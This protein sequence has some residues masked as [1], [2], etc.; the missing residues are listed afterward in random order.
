MQ[1]KFLI[2]ST[3]Y[4]SQ[5]LANFTASPPASPPPLLSC[6][7]PIPSFC[8]SLAEPHFYDVSCY[9]DANVSVSATDSLISPPAYG[10]LGCN[11]GGLVCCRFCEFG[12]YAN[13]SC[14]ESPSP[15]P[16]PPASPPSLPLPPLPPAPPN[17]P[18][19]NAPPHSPRPCRDII[20][21]YCDGLV[22]AHYFDVN[23]YAHDDA[24]G[25]L[26]CNAG[27]R[28]CCRFCEFGNY[29]N[30]SCIQSP[31]PPPP[32]NPLVLSIPISDPSLDL[33][34]KQSRIEFNLRIDANLESFNSQRFKRKLRKL[35]AP[36]ISL[37]NILLRIRLGSIIVDILILTNISTAQNTSYTIEKMTPETLSQELNV[38]VIEMSPPI[39]IEYNASL[40]S[41]ED[42]DETAGV[43]AGADSSADGMKGAL[44]GWLMIAVLLALMLIFSLIRKRRQCKNNRNNKKRKEVATKLFE[45]ECKLDGVA[46][47]NQMKISNIGEDVDTDEEGSEPA[48]TSRQIV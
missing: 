34:P 26:G 27:G 10:N 28:L 3:I 29:E 17:I 31:S 40:H 42:T 48:F 35:V 45:D 9:Y 43:G 47:L 21:N 4:F 37:A 23:C 19:P 44:I 46:R 39:L 22:E 38:S 41:G 5:I 36:R 32:L 30:I 33:K 16:I 15:P 13:I 18:S 6:Y 20:P 24:Y 2:L 8:D 11:A 12:L 25:N 1:S 14:R 7:P